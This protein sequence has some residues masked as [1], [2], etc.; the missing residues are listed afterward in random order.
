MIRN[1]DLDSGRFKFGN[2]ASIL[3]ILNYFLGYN[4]IYPTLAS[5]IYPPSQNTLHPKAQMISTLITLILSIYLVR[6]TLKRSFRYFKT[7]I[8]DNS[9]VIIRGLLTMYGLNIVLS[10]I[11]YMISGES[12][13]G[14]QELI[15]SGFSVYPVLYAFTA[16]IFA[17]IVEELIFR[18]VLYQ[19]LRSKNSYKLPIIISSVSFGLIHTLPIYLSGGNSVEM[20]FLLVYTAMGFILT[21]VYEKTGSIYSSISLHLLNNLIAT[22]VLITNL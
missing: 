21:M 13:T 3:L 16:V 17:P 7:R 1:K 15:E 10:L 4:L 8:G 19:E 20:L 5:L 6:D 9:K 14:N 11:I 2:K 12:T 18:G 22:I